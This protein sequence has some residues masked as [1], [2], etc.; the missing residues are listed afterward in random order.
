MTD[1][2]TPTPAPAGF[3][4]QLRGM[5]RP[6]AAS[7]EK[8]IDFATPGAASLGRDFATFDPARMARFEALTRAV[9]VAAA[10]VTFAGAWAKG[11][12]ID[13]GDGAIGLGIA[14]AMGAIAL[15]Y[16]RW[17]PA[18][19]L[20]AGAQML[21]EQMLYGVLFIY[22]SYV[23]VAFGGAEQAPLLARIDAWLGFDWRAYRDAIDAIPALRAVMQE[24]Y[25]SIAWQNMLIPVALIVCGRLGWTRVFMNTFALGC[26]ATMVIAMLLPAVDAQ[27]FY[28]FDVLRD[29]RPIT[30]AAITDDYLA[31]RGGLMTSLDFA[32]MTG[33]I[34][35][36][37]FHTYLALLY[38]V[39]LWPLR[40]ARW[41]LIP[42]NLMLIAA[43][44][45]FGFHFLADTI[46]GAL[47]AALV[48]A[49]TLAW[50]RRPPAAL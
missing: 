8:D 44:P 31:I 41:L 15:V 24:C 14:V 5:L 49:P 43:T 10:V 28:V 3:A 45:K 12:R 36:P 19:R 1:A 33:I 9:V 18:P 4:A 6:N 37:S 23:A 30:G 20:A 25:V 22:F 13:L 35:F 21:A 11:L 39:C 2:T 47:L 48:L 32:A 42:V 17:R 29:Q 34:S 7:I 40:R 16:H 50:L 38:I 26:A 46:G 27:G